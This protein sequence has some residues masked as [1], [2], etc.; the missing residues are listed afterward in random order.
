MGINE[1][2]IREFIIEL[3]KNPRIKRFKPGSI[4]RR[5]AIEV[6]EVGR[7]CTQLMI[8]GVLEPLY[9]YHCGCGHVSTYTDIDDIPTNC[10]LC[11][12]ITDL[13]N[14]YI[15]FAFKK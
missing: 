8:E 12:G 5:F 2:L 9:C 11:D 15:E 10:E 6:K 4:S 14:V 13:Y 7:Y 3:S 1:K